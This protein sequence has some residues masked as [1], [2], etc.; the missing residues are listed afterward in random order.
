MLKKS[1]LTASG[2]KQLV[3]AGKA[4]PLAAGKPS[5]SQKRK[6]EAGRSPAA[7]RPKQNRDAAQ[8]SIK[9]FFTASPGSKS[10][11]PPSRGMLAQQPE[12]KQEPSLD[13]CLLSGV[14]QQPVA[15]LSDEEDITAE[16]P[17]VKP[18]VLLN[19]GLP[20][21]GLSRPPR[22][23][24]H[25]E[26]RRN[27]AADGD[28][29]VAPVTLCPSNT[30]RSVSVDMTQAP[31]VQLPINAPESA[32]LPSLPREQAAGPA[33]PTPPV[34]AVLFPFAEYEPVEYACWQPGEPTPYLHLARAFQVPNLSRFSKDVAL[35]AASLCGSTFKP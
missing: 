13:P 3:S 10:V 12:Q 33:R 5:L 17:L 26:I 11:Q 27:A 29:A 32:G 15:L 18:A 9:S 16:Q 14:A 8:R 24:N 20:S 25:A 30:L 4:Q 23:S 6:P 31:A 1:T 28:T 35:L 34:D 19:S 7:K 22:D 21:V 2:P